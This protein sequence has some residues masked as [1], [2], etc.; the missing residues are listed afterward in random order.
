MYLQV[1][2]PWPQEPATAAF[3]LPQEGQLKGLLEWTILLQVSMTLL[4]L[5]GLGIKEP[6]L[7]PRELVAFSP[8]SLYKQS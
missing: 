5:L 1:S 2:P 8:T 6:S 4:P 3:L 7:R